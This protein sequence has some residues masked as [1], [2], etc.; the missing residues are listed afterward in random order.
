MRNGIKITEN[1]E[2]ANEFNEFFVNVG[3]N[4][5]KNI[6]DRDTDIK[7]NEYLKD[8]NKEKTMFVTPT[9]ENEISNIVA[10]FDGKTS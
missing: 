10:K 7:Y 2:I 9:T 8:I 6:N 4:L 5:A 1:K 3:A